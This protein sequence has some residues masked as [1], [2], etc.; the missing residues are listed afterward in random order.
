MLQRY[1]NALCAQ[2]SVTADVMWFSPCAVAKQNEVTRRRNALHW[3]RY[4]NGQYISKPRL[5]DVLKHSAYF[6]G[7]CIVCIRLHNKEI[8]FIEKSGMVD[9]QAANSTICVLSPGL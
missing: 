6:S 7:N 9:G 1:S 5:S 4:R 3:A 8:D 2:V